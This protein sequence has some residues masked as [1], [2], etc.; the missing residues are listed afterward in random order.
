MKKDAYQYKDS[1]YTGLHIEIHN[2][3]RK[4]AVILKQCPGGVSI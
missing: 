4:A 1:L 2:I 3:A